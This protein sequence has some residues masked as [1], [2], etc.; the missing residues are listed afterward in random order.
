ML[1]HAA[2]EHVSPETDC[3]CVPGRV[4]ECLLVV[5]CGKAE[6][7]APDPESAVVAAREL[8]ADRMAARSPGY[9]SVSFH[10]V[11]GNLLGALDGLR[12]ARLMDG[13]ESV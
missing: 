6:A 11:D 9:M 8:M 2:A 3:L 10:D 7:F 1:S 13:R 4:E 12:L 5:R